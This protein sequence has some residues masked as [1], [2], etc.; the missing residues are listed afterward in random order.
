MEKKDEKQLDLIDYDYKYDHLKILNL[1]SF[2]NSEIEKAKEKDES[3]LINLS[4]IIT[5]QIK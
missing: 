5:D 2:V 4:D 3:L 1:D